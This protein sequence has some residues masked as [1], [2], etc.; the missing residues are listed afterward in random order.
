MLLRPTRTA[1]LSFRISPE[2]KPEND[3]DLS[4]RVAFPFPPM[5]HRVWP[6]EA[7]RT[8]AVLRL[9]C[10]A[11]PS[12]ATPLCGRPGCLLAA[13]CRLTRL[14]RPQAGQRQ[15]EQSSARRSRSHTHSSCNEH[16]QNF[17]QEI[18]KLFEFDFT[19]APAWKRR[20]PREEDR[21]RNR[22]GLAQQ[23]IRLTRARLLPPLPS[24]PHAL[25]SHCTAGE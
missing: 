18:R 10:P 9:P 8:T 6:A 17:A 4:L 23:H 22:Q 3:G 11:L 15:A 25:C 2:M 20:A 16:G 24:P 14:G 13:A 21:D 1:G 7:A 19:T 12:A 5:M